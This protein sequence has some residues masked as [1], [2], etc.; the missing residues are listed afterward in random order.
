M[1]IS[2]KEMLK[3]YRKSGWIVLRHKG[4]HVQVAITTSEGKT[5]HET[6]P[7]HKELKKGIEKSLL[8]RLKEVR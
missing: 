4:S 7:L 2:G 6:I 1:P 5:E 8:K 3:R